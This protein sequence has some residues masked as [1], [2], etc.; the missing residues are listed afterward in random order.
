MKLKSCI[1]HP[2][3]AKS[4]AQFV[5][6]CPSSPYSEG[7]DQPA[8]QAPNLLRQTMML[9]CLHC[10]QKC[11]VQAFV[12]ETLDVSSTGGMLQVIAK[13][14]ERGWMIGTRGSKGV[15]YIHV[16]ARCLLVFSLH[17][18]SN[19]SRHFRTLDIWYLGFRVARCFLRGW[20]GQNASSATSTTWGSSKTNKKKGCWTFCVFAPVS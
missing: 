15:G 17:G 5:H 3:F 4:W 11:I 16:T 14:K 7:C 9:R 13:W 1:W 12:S 18:Y 10:P 8:R 20:R 19:D 2:P 6:V